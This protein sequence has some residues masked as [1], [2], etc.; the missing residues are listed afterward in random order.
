MNINNIKKL[1][2]DNKGKI[3]EVKLNVG[4]NKFEYFTGQIKETYPYLFTIKKENELK[5]FSYS[6]ILTKTLI[7]KFN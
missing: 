2:E 4:R 6:D 5:S 1:I 3:V 7:M